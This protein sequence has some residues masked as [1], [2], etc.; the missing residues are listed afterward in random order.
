MTDG[1]R[2]PATILVLT[3]DEL[4][5][6]RIEST[7]RSDGRWCV[8]VGRLADSGARI[9]ADRPDGVVLAASPERA[10]RV[11]EAMAASALPV[12]LL[13][14][15]AP[16]SW[17]WQKRAANLRAVLRDDA[18]SEEIRAALAAVLAGLVVLH[19]ET[20][21]GAPTKAS[22]RSGGALTARELTILEMM[23]EGVDNRRIALRL[24]ISRNT[25]KFH[26]ASILDKLHASSRTE[27]VTVAIREGRISV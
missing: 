13:T 3:D 14:P 12:M 23:A 17:K 1:G 26:V 16:D 21:A 22:S 25:V 9:A 6:A 4:R 10:A 7:L 27:A 11:L 15:G 24:R 20:A 18:T 19:P 2:R 8:K 5:A